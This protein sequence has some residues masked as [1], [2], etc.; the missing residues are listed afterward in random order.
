MR[1]LVSVLCWFL[2]F[3]YP[4]FEGCQRLDSIMR[5]HGVDYSSSVNKG[6][7]RSL[8]KRKEEE[9]DGGD[10]DDSST[11]KKP[12]VVWLVELH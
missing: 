8:R 1:M 4:Q 2:F 6:N 12:H 10:K 11:L 7:W 9:D 5:N 3:S